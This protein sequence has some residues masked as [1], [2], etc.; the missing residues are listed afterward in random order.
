MCACQQ[1]VCMRL[2]QL[3]QGQGKA[4]HLELQAELR[5]RHS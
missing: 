2:E 1:R 5:E 4:E 3:W